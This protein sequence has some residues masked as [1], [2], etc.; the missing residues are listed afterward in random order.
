[1][2][3]ISLGLSQLSEFNSFFLV[4][5]H[6]CLNFVKDIELLLLYF[7]FV[8]L[9]GDHADELVDLSEEVYT[10]DSA[11]TLDVGGDLSELILSDMDELSAVVCDPEKSARFLK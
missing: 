9:S 3:L 5:L 8:S 1:M 7:I 11:F 2:M 4:S 6:R 10:A